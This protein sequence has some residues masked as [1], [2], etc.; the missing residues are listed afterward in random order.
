M[1][2]HTMVKLT[3][4]CHLCATEPHTAEQQHAV[5]CRAGYV[6]A[7]R[8][9]YITQTTSLWACTQYTIALPIQL[10]TNMYTLVIVV[11]EYCWRGMAL[12]NKTCLVHTADST[13][14]PS[15]QITCSKMQVNSLQG[16]N[17]VYIRTHIHSRVCTIPQSLCRQERD[18][19][20]ADRVPYQN[21]CMVY[22]SAPR[23]SANTSPRKPVGQPCI[24]PTA[25]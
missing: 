25:F 10:K 12:A 17:Y 21:P 24:F 5:Q 3:V 20:V 16:E 13:K 19:D 22:D 4:A 11:C 8:Q 9:L 7:H 15:T 23:M 18:S 2:S 14:K 1:P 6:C